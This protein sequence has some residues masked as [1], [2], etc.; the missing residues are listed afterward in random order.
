[1]TFVNTQALEEFRVRVLAT[2]QD[3]MT[4]QRVRNE[5]RRGREAVGVVGRKEEKGGKKGRRK[6]S[7][8]RSAAAVG[9]FALRC[10]GLARAGGRW[11]AV[12]MGSWY[13]AL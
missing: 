11:L 12:G 2:W 3:R 4:S 7:Q 13:P 8:Q 1:L 9:G 10:W 6:N 5:V